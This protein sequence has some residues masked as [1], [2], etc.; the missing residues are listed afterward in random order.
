MLAQRLRGSG[1]PGTATISL[2]TCT[3]PL[4]VPLLPSKA[5]NSALA[6]NLGASARL[7]IFL[8]P[9]ASRSFLQVSS[10]SKDHAYW[11]VALPVCSWPSGP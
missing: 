9:D 6:Q 5:T 10:Q 2:P 11:W 4:L 3:V 1:H 8:A 7:C